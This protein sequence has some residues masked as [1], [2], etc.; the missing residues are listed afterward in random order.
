MTVSDQYRIDRMCMTCMAWGSPSYDYGYCYRHPHTVK[1][2]S[3]NWCCDHIPDEQH[4]EDET[5][6]YSVFDEEIM[7]ANIPG[8]FHEEVWGTDE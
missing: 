5:S 8:P 6:V 4:Q 3:H 7:A 2:H 1:K